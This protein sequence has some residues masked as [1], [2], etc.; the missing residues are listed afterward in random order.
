LDGQGDSFAAGSTGNPILARPF[1]NADPGVNAQDSLLV[2]YPGVSQ[3]GIDAL[4][5]IDV[6]GF[7]VF[8]RY[9]L[10]A[11]YCNRIDFIGGYHFTEIEDT[12][13]VRHNIVSVDG[14]THG[15]VGTTID[16]VDRFIADNEFNGGSIGFISEAEDGRLTWSLLTKI[17]FGNMRQRLTVDGQTTTT[18]PGAGSATSNFGLLT[19]P[20]NIGVFERDEFAYVPELSVGVGYNLH[21]LLR[22]SVGYNV[23]YWSDVAYA[24]EAVDTTINPTQTTGGLVGEARPAFRFPDSRSFWTQGLSF[25]VHGRF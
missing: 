19:M 22:V 6:S 16:T 13:R 21:S 8:G 25:G 20:S 9:L 17:S 23:I 12:L 2:A 18:V 4:S 14:I 10:Y 15:P 3:G 11:G 5:E 7:D 1:F 24:G